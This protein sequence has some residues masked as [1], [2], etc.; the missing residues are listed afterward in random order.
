VA[1]PLPFSEVYELH[2]SSVFRF[3][4]SQVRQAAVAED[5]ASGVFVSAWQAY[6]R[7][8]PEPDV[9]RQWLFSIAR[10]KI[11][12]HF[13]HERRWGLLFARI[14]GHDS[15]ASVEDTAQYRAELQAAL[16]GIA[17]LRGR[18]RQL[19]GLRLAAGL[20]IAEIAGVMGMSEGAAKVALQRAV[21]KVRAHVDDLQ[22]MPH[23]QVQSHGKRVS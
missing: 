15:A 6:G 12:D 23:P 17:S 20:P 13:R 10:N 9:V 3:C 18:D 21:K 7:A 22:A 5:I 8:Q 14:G 16:T 1:Q 4:V 2:A 19:V 11:I